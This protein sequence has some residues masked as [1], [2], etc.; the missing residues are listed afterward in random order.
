MSGTASVPVL[1]A[2]M[3]SVCRELAGADDGR[4]LQ[5]LRYVDGLPDRGQADGL[6]APLRDRLRRLR[7]PRPLRFARLLF[8][9]LDPVIVAARDWR[10]GAPQ[11]PRS[12][13]API[14]ALVRR[15]LPECVPA[16]EA[17]INDEGRS[18]AS[19]IHDGG[20]MLWA[21]AAAL[22][23]CAPMPPEW[24]D[25]A[26]PAAAFRT[27]AAGCARCLGSADL[28]A[29][30]SDPG[31]LPADLDRALAFQIKAAEA[32]GPIAWG[33]F[34]S[35]ILQ[36]FPSAE[37]PH[38][39]AMAV[40]A[41]RALRQSAE[42]ALEA[43]WTWI[44]EAAA[45][46]SVGDPAEAA[47]ALRRQVGLLEALLREPRQRRRAAGLQAELRA[48]CA[49]RLDALAQ[50]RLVAPLARLSAAEAEDDVVLAVLES[51]ARAL[52]QLDA[53]GR[54]LGSGAGCEA[55]LLAAAAAVRARAD[56]A[57]MDRARLVEILLG[58][59]AALA[60]AAQR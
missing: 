1:G 40:R 27:L 2:A 50:E 13:I 14:L 56:M 8:L 30:L 33:M 28:L 7:P 10:A 24:R 59:K 44:E 3:R 38:R 47:A 9:P 37:A 43:A 51:D 35:V 12:A 32:D 52:R 58:P 18:E 57:P 4:V 26:L 25:A 54:R 15:A 11:L 21:P 23:R 53:E 5:V 45:D 55:P 41:D 20:A 19:R 36:R 60:E 46:R 22:L 16:I 42:A 49:H 39:A 17:I 6:L 34:L 31:M 48:A 29:D